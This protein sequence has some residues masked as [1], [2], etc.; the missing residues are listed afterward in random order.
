MLEDL[1]DLGKLLA[2]ALTQDNGE[3]AEEP[4]DNEVVSILLGC[5]ERWQD[6]HKFNAGDILLH[7][8]PRVATTRGAKRPIIFLEYW[9]QPQILLTDPSD[10]NSSAAATTVDCRIGV[11]IDGEFRTFLADSSE[12][13]PHPRFPAKG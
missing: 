4:S 3:Q 7:K 6:T 9:E 8:W 11:Y 5:A 13:R 10:L 2:Q 1:D 12:Y